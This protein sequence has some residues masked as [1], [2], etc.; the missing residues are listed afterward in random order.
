MFDQNLTFSSFIYSFINI[1]G[2]FF[3]VAS[4]ENTMMHEIKMVSD[5]IEVHSPEETNIK[6]ITLKN[7]KFPL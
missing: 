2:F 4:L 6:E 7:L 5:L 3:F 1:E